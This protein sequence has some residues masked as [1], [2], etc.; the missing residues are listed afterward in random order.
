MARSASTRRRPAARR[1]AAG[2]RR[3]SGRGR[4]SR[5][6]RSPLL[7]NELKREL[8]GVAAIGLALIIAAILILPGTGSVARPVHDAFYAVLGAGAWLVVAGLAV[9]GVRLT[10]SSAWR[11]GEAAAGGSLLA[12]LALLGLIGLM[13]PGSAGAVGRWLG[14]GIARGLGNA[15]AGATLIVLAVIGVVMAMDLRTWPIVQA[16][17]AW[18]GRMR[19]DDDEEVPARRANQRAFVAPVA[20]PEA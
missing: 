18:L 15:G 2:T 14:P 19:E 9:T 16:A 12:V 5:T 6:S 4:V 10:A 8:I 17:A 3:P 11:A 20:P 1:P 13:S 7:S